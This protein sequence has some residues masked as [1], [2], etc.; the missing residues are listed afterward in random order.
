MNNILIL[1]DILSSKDIN[2]LHLRKTLIMVSLLF[3]LFIIGSLSWNISS[4][5]KEIRTIAENTARGAFDKDQSFRFWSATHGG[6]YVPA[7]KETPSNINLAHIKDRDIYKPD[8]TK[9]TLMNPAYMI[10]QMMNKYP[11]LYGAKG[12]ITSLKYVYEGNKP[13][14]WETKALQS[15]ENGNDEVYEYSIKNGKEHLR[16]MRPMYIKQ[17]CLKCHAV[18]GY[19]L[20]D[21][22][23]GVGISVP[24][25]ILNNRANKHIVMLILSH[26]GLWL[27]ALF[28]V[29]F[30]ALR[31]R[32]YLIERDK[33]HKE[34]LLE[35]NKLTNIFE[36]MTDGIYIVNDKFDI[37]YI[38]PVLEKEFGSPKG[39]KCYEYFHNKTEKC[40]WC[41]IDDI[42]NG[43]T[44]RWE[45]F[46]PKNNK[47]YDLVDTP[48]KNAD[49][50]I[51]KLEIFRDVT[52]LKEVHQTLEKQEEIMI[53]QSRHAAMG[54]MIS[55]I[56]H[57]WRQPLSVISMGANNIMADIE[58][59]MVDNDRL[60]NSAVEIIAQTQE[61]S[62]TID[63]FKNFFRPM[64]TVETILIKDIFEDALKIVGKSLENNDVQ[65]TQELNSKN[66]IE[67]YSRELM[68][69]FINIIKNAK[70]IIV[71]RKIIEKKIEII[72]NDKQDGIEIKICDNGGGIP[73]NI[74]DKIFNPYFSTKDEGSGT[75][76]GLYMSK[77]IIEKHLNGTISVY[78]TKEGACFKIEL[79]YK[80]KMENNN[81]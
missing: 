75:G 28:S 1:K 63:D 7:T 10:R 65:L 56:A 37:E 14:K 24:M 8:G 60:K 9:L 11:G 71:E 80:L 32:T 36:S 67:T 59:E 4:E 17:G 3:T 74:I 29:F 51:S 58:L 2:T 54:E 18:H 50:S 70:E 61:L 15:F 19:K 47:L 49:G 64:K 41:K 38:N 52:E 57:Q 34:L 5:Y 40:S 26:I 46:S 23:G 31:E 16:L 79:P 43:Q 78:N 22:R 39:K 55:M 33:S 76:L 69:V 35:R 72:I 25:E 42:M 48:L 21:V 53:A 13:D 45:W 68:Q 30:F 77:T 27:L 73:N 62:K 44:V 12:R 20:G 6:V 66:S 81:G